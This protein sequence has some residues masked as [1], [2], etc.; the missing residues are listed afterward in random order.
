MT[1]RHGRRRRQK[2]RKVRNRL[3]NAWTHDRLRRGM[4]PDDLFLTR[5][6]VRAA[7]AYAP[8][9]QEGS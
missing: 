5:L 3:C 6:T 4:G 9:G 1:N 8:V 2:R 7:M